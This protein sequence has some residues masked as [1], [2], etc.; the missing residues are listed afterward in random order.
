M[1]FFTTLKLPKGLALLPRLHCLESFSV[2]VLISVWY[3]RHI[4]RPDPK[5]IT[6]RNVCL[7][8][9]KG[10]EILVDC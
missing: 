2:A 6:I 8:L 3:V 9:E 4:G 7:W 10:K 5:S 1:K